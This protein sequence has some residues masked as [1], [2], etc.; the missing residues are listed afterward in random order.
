MKGRMGSECERRERLCTNKQGGFTFGSCQHGMH[1]AQPNE[2]PMFSVLL[3]P[4]MSAN[5]SLL[6]PSASAM[7]AP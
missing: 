1:K 6:M 3:E 7:G 4:C 5:L 2:L